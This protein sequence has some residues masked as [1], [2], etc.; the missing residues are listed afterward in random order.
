VVPS[1]LTI[2]GY[3]YDVRIGRLNEV[4]AATKAGK[5]KTA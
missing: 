4:K 5:G 3:I 2:Y 1:N